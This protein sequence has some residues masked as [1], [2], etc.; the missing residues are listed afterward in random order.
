MRLIFTSDL[1][2][3][4]GGETGLVYLIS[5]LCHS[6]KCKAICRSDGPLVERLRHVGADVDI[7][8]Y[9]NKTNLP[10]SIWALRKIIVAFKPD[11]IF[12]NDP[13]TACLVHLA[14]PHIDNYWI[15][16]GQWYEFDCV[17]RYLISKSISRAL[18][19]SNAAEK[20]LQSQ[21]FLNCCT[22]YLGVPT[23]CF[24]NATPSNLRESFG[25]DN[26]RL[27]VA[28]I[29]RFQEI[30][31]QLKGVKAVE[32]A[33]NKGLNITYLLIGGSV[34]GSALD[35]AYERKVRNYVKDNGLES[36]VLFLGERND[37]DSIMKE[38]DILLIP[39]DNE[40]FG[41]VAIE[42]IASGVP[43]I[44]TPNDGVREIVD[45]NTDYISKTNDSEGL[46]EL[47]LR[48]KSKSFLSDARTGLD[49]YRNK[50]DIKTV[51][52]S[53]IKAITNRTIH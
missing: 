11:C 10:I 35:D 48:Y 21:G 8:D 4:G 17:R 18:C 37:I 49:R 15:C 5:E 30:K 53:Y 16:H 19:V 33:L 32:I 14:V 28:T 40:S 1:S 27:L 36:H 52:S 46:A 41:V 25:I 44:S 24:S 7:L 2:G 50:F 47:L 51:A 22:V 42:A 39:S 12:N 20:N 45:G 6:H 29:A 13:M 31:G 9:K 34:F 43:L 3:M 38:I 23:E 26:D